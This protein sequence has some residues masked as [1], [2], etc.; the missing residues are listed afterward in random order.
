MWPY[1]NENTDLSVVVAGWAE[2]TGGFVGRVVDARGVFG[3]EA[4]V[5]VGCVWGR[6]RE[7]KGGKESGDAV[8]TSLRSRVT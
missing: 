5:L 2:E 4:F 8:H 7:G 6:G 1:L 3:V